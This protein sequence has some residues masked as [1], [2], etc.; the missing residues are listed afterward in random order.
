MRKDFLALSAISLLVVGVFW[1]LFSNEPVESE[2]ILTNVHESMPAITPIIK[3][4]D[5]NIDSFD[6]EK[7]SIRRNEFLADILTRKGIPYQQIDRMVRQEKER[8]DVRK[9]KTGQTYAFVQPKDTL[10][11]DRFFIY[12]ENASVYWVFHFGDSLFVERKE[13]PVVTR[14]QYAEGM[15]DQS[16]WMS[17]VDNA[18]PPLLAIEL[19]E[20]YAWSI[21]FFGI[22]RGDSFR[23]FYQEDFVD[24]VSIG[25]RSVEAAFF[26]HKGYDYWA[27]GFVQD[28]VYAFFDEHGQSLRKAFLKA[29][30]RYS[31]ISSGF[32]H[33]RR[34]PVLKI[35]RP[36]HGIDYA[37]PKGTPVYSIG[38]GLVVERGYQKSGGGNYV[39][40]KHNSVYTSVYM[41]L[42]GFAKGLSKGDRVQQGQLIGYVGSTG[43]STGPHL[44]FRIYQ[45]GSPVNPLH[46]KSPPVD[47]IKPE[48]AVPFEGTWKHWK[49]RFEVYEP[50][51]TSVG[52]VT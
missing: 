40:I 8:F 52:Q 43:L 41:H 46:V 11:R 29:P 38:D 49:A 19:S 10:N 47:P 7:A 1:Y 30:L 48:N 44:D 32:S 33:S 14:L 35:Y 15:I 20:I 24:S 37:A 2:E 4:Y 45:N 28:S 5:F 9:I 36:H 39:K 31:R 50:K 26:Q 13:K 12:E 21:D 42:Q 34:H 17:M 51:V 18:Y 6:I 27:I 23:V 16:L 22:Q 25:I 3:E